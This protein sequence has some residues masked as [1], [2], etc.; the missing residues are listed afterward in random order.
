[1]FEIKARKTLDFCVFHHGFTRIFKIL[2]KSRLEKEKMDFI[3]EKLRKRGGAGLRLQFTISTSSTSPKICCLARFFQISAGIIM[4]KYAKKNCHFDWSRCPWAV[5]NWN[6]SHI[7]FYW[8]VKKLKAKC[9]EGLLHWVLITGQLFMR[10]QSW[11]SVWRIFDRS[12]ENTPGSSTVSQV[13]RNPYPAK[14][15]ATDPLSKVKLNPLSPKR[16]NNRKWRNRKWRNFKII[17]IIYVM[18]RA[19]KI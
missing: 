15:L 16:S 17:W 1:M 14:L 3:L 6:P 9:F 13:N 5:F 12:A 19:K 2:Q 11:R 18:S 7:P 10:G 8:L 4:I